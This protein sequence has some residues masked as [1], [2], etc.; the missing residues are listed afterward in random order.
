M[1]FLVFAV[2]E[3]LGIA[4]QVVMSEEKTHHQL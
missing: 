2:R 1:E 4:L 3:S